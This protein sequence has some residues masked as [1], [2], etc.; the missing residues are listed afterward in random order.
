M[1][2]KRFTL[3]ELLVVIAIIAILAAMLLPALNQAR[4]RAR[5]TSCLNNLKQV[6]TYYMFYA[7]SYNGFLIPN[8]DQ[9]ANPYYPWVAALGKAGILKVS[10][11]NTTAESLSATT[12]DR[13]TCCPAIKAPSGLRNVRFSYG[14]VYRYLNDN[15]KAEG[16]TKISNPIPSARSTIW[17]NI[18]SHF[19]IA[20]DS[21]RSKP[22]SS[23]LINWQWCVGDAATSY[24]AIH[25]RHANR[26]N[27][28]MLD[29]SARSATKNELCK[30]SGLLYDIS[31][32]LG[33]T[34]PNNIISIVQE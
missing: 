24:R 9:T 21:V 19:V 17:R 26:T 3:I 12:T 33:A 5:A 7:D 20:I 6:G 10:D 14:T 29:G 27:M 15:T 8:N 2:G 11:F 31:G 28:A 18:P 34:T 22:D 25:M 1:S 4:E 30:R 13:S 32:H 23:S 16:L